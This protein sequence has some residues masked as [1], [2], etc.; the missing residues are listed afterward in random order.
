MV[1]GTALYQASTFNGSLM[2]REVLPSSG[3]WSPLSSAY[4]LKPKAHCFILFKQ[5][6]FWAFDLALASAG[7]SRAARIAMMAI[8]TRSSISVKARK[9]SPLGENFDF[10]ASIL[11]VVLG[12]PAMGRVYPDTV[13]Q[14]KLPALVWVASETSK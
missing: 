13:F 3:T 4:I 7:S 8:T 14:I 12:Y 6:I 9:S 10:E 1:G 5:V 2:E 11:S